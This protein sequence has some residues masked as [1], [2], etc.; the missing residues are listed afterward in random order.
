MNLVEKLGKSFVITT[1]LGPVKGVLTNGKM[2]SN[3]CLT[4][5]D[6]R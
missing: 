4:L 3:L 1:E 5:G 2:G 6:K